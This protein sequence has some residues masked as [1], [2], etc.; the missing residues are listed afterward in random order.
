MAD[1]R[2]F[3]K[4]AWDAVSGALSYDAEVINMA[5]TVVASKPDILGLEVAVTDLP[6]LA[7][8]VSYNFRVRARDTFG[9]GAFSTNLAFRIVGPEAPTNVHIV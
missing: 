1:I 2:S 7:Q 8:G 9:V 3:N 5:L 4:F 6:G